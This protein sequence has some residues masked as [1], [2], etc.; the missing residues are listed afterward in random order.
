MSDSISKRLLS[1]LDQIDRPITFSAS[2]ELPTV[3]PGLEVT[4]VGPISLPLGK[5]QAELLMHQ[6]RQAPYGKGTKTVVDTNVRRVWEIDSQSITHESHFPKSKT[7]RARP[8]PPRITNL[9]DP[10]DLTR[11]SKSQ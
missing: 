8:E 7:P 10:R 5:Q 3:F 2:G 4:G 1:F 11:H 6:A 9:P